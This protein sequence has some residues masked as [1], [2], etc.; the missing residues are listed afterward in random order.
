MQEIK[1]V[2]DGDN[3]KISTNCGVED[4]SKILARVVYDSDPEI[5]KI[6]GKDNKFHKIHGD[7]IFNYALKFMTKTLE[8]QG[9]KKETDEPAI[10][11]LDGG[12][13]L[14]GGK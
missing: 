7:E 12:F 5:E 10:S 2:V 6:F 11:S 14:L 8:L 9:S 1:I 13:N 4:F 3:L